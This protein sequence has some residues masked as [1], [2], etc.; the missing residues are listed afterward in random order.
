MWQIFYFFVEIRFFMGKL[1]DGTLSLRYPRKSLYSRFQR[2]IVPRWLD[3]DQKNWYAIDYIYI[4]INVPSFIE[5]S[6]TIW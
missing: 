5:L 4:S 3:L 6:Q 2:A 1:A